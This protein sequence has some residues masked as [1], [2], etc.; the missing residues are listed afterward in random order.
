MKLPPKGAPPSLAPPPIVVEAEATVEASP[1]S[2][3]GP[4]ANSIRRFR[5]DDDYDPGPNPATVGGTVG[6]VSSGNY[7][8]LRMDVRCEV[9]S[10]PELEHM[11][12]R[13]NMAFELAMKVLDANCPVLDKLQDSLGMTTPGPSP[14]KPLNNTFDVHDDVKQAG[15]SLL[16]MLDGQEDL[17]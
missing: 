15:Q 12:K 1:K 14:A 16:V 13:T 8:S 6:F 2:P 7:R 9:P 10:R 3:D 5:F 17:A 4:K 11:V